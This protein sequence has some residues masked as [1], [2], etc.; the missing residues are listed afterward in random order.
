MQNLVVVWSFASY[1]I[2]LDSELTCTLDE[3]LMI[4]KNTTERKGF[5]P[6][7]ILP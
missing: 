4:Y 2:Q 5:G 3:M 7:W 1:E 6:S